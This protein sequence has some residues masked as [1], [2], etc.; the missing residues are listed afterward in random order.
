MATTTA[1][2]GTTPPAV[3]PQRGSL[4][5][6][7]LVRLVLLMVL[8]AVGGF[9]FLY[10]RANRLVQSEPYQAALKYVTQSKLVKDKVGEPLAQAGF[11]DFLRD[12]SNVSDND[13]QLQFKVISPQGPIEVLGS[14]RKRD[15][16]WSIQS[17]SVTLPNSTERL[18]LMS[19]II[20]DTAGD[21]PKFNPNEQPP[22][23][24]IKIDLPPPDTDIKI[25]IPGD[26]PTIP[27][28]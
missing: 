15:N 17:L 20:V 14:G 11:I 2:S 7:L 8:V 24:E 27:E 13:A 28:K 4:W 12:G 6:R 25:E 1:K 22:K 9:G 19:E 10:F 21:T 23:N 3:T 18:N 16:A 5:K 26:L